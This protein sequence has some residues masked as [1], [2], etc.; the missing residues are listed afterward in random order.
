MS[1][2]RMRMGIGIVAG[3]GSLL[4]SAGLLATSAW[5]ISRASQHPPILYLMVAIVAVRAFGLGR[6][7]LRYAERLV[8]HDAAL[9]ALAGHRGRVFERFAKLAPAGLPGG[10]A[11][12]RL[13]LVVSAVDG[14]ADRWLRGLLPIAS[15]GV[16]AL[17]VAG[18]E[19][20]LLPEA[21]AVLLAALVAGGLVAPLASRSLMVAAARRG[22]AVR[23]EL[24]ALA[25][26]TLDGLDELTAYGAVPGLLERLRA[27]DGEA[28][29][30]ATRSAWT[31]GLG[32]ALT[33]L[34]CGAAV[35]GALLAGV[36]AVRHGRLEPVLLAVV[37]LA[38]L[39]AFEP[40]GALS[41]A[42]HQLLRSRAD[43]ARLR[44]LLDAPD[45]VRDPAVAG[46][47]SVSSGLVVRV[48]GAW[49][50][51]PGGERVRLPDLELRPGRR[52]ALLGPSGS[53]KSTLAAVLLRFLDYEG[54]VTLGGVELRDLPGD[55][56]RKLIGICAQDAHL[57]DTTVAANL[58]L[59]KPEANDREVRT[60]LERAGLGGRRVG[61][62]T[63]VGVHGTAVSGGEH[64][65]IAL[66]RALLADFPILILDEPDA[67]LDEATAQALLPDLLDS[68]GDR[69]ILL[70]THRA[71]FPGD[72]PILRHV[73]E[74][75][76]LPA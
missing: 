25:G 37:V 59:A 54:S 10:S 69:S 46:V 62:A 1:G 33:G 61:P 38:P 75:I 49:A 20:W 7:V 76:T 48:A 4:A 66:A 17:A 70:I 42:T 41:A 19:W 24:A 40:L 43:R 68:A 9:R 22:A 30:S 12:D 73:D 23:T 39:A 55:A 67:H 60:A 16:A 13:D 44:A 45:P 15:A 31:A 6:G 27:L 53:G 35:C 32:A 3:A 74:V 52:L 65:R 51:W 71:A 8:S 29:R 14:V 18:L 21:G 64:R 11:P 26:Q 72:H 50:S 36:S 63:R 56:V 57:F 28:C 5:L 34:S 47:S 2:F 58:R